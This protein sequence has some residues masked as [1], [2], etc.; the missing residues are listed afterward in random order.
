MQNK[1]LTSLLLLCSSLIC[2]A[3]WLDVHTQI[4]DHLNGVAVNRP[5]AL[6]AGD[7]GLYYSTTGVA[8]GQWQ[9]YTVRGSH[10]DSLVYEHTRFE[11][12]VEGTGATFYACGEDTVAHT[13]ILL[14]V[15]VDAQLYTILYTGSTG[16]A[17][18]QVDDASYNG[19]KYI[20]SAGRAG[21]LVCYAS[22]GST[23]V[24]PTGVTADLVGLRIDYGFATLAAP[25]GVY[26]TNVQG[27]S[28]I[29]PMRYT[30]MTGMDIH[31]ALQPGLITYMGWAVGSKNLQW[32]FNS[33]LVDRAG[34]DHG[35]LNATCIMPFR[36]YC[37]T[38]SDHGI[39]RRASN[40][41]YFMEI[42]PSTLGHSFSSMA[43]SAG[44]DSAYACGD[45]GLLMTTA[46]SGATIPYA[47]IRQ[48]GACVNIPLTVG[49][50]SG[51]GSKRWYKNGVYVGSNNSFT[52]TSATPRQD[53]ITLIMTNTQG[54]AD[55]VSQIAYIV[56]VPTI[57][58]PVTVS[59]PLSC[60]GAPTLIRLDT[61]EANVRYWITDY[62]THRVCSDTAT[63]TGRADTIYG[64]PQSTYSNYVIQASNALAYCEA[65]STNP[66]S[67]ASEYTRARFYADRANAYPGESVHLYQQ[68]NDASYYSWTLSPQPN[69]VSG[70]QSGVATA[71]WTIPGPTQVTLICIS[72]HGCSDTIT[73]PGPTITAEAPADSCWT[74]RHRGGIPYPLSPVSGTLTA[75]LG[76]YVQAMYDSITAATRAG[77]STVPGYYRTLGGYYLARYS[78]NGTMRWQIHTNGT[79]KAVCVDHAQHLYV[80]G[81]GSWLIDNR[82]DSLASGIV[83]PVYYP[84]TTYLACLDSNGTTLWMR[85]LPDVGNI[86]KITADYDGNIIAACGSSTIS[87]LTQVTVWNGQTQLSYT[88]LRDSSNFA[89]VKFDTAGMPLWATSFFIGYLNRGGISGLQ[90]DKYGNIYMAGQTDGGMYFYSDDSL[91]H[92]DFARSGIFVN[93][94]DPSGHMMWN[95]RGYGGIAPYD[96]TYLQSMYTDSTGRTY[97][98]GKCGTDTMRITGTDQV[99]TMLVYPDGYVASIGPAGDCSWIANVKGL[100]SINTAMLLAPCDSGVAVCIAAAPYHAATTSDA[101]IYGSGGTYIDVQQILSSYMIARYTDRGDLLNTMRSTSDSFNC[102]FEML[103]FASA[104]PATY[105][106]HRLQQMLTPSSVL[107][108]DMGVAFQTDRAH[109]YMTS[110]VTGYRGGLLQRS[111]I[112]SVR[113]TTCPHTPYYWHGRTCYAPGWYYD[114]LRV[115]GGRDSIICL[116]LAAIPPVY[117]WM[118]DTICYGD[119]AYF[120]GTY[121][122]QSGIYRDTASIAGGCDSVTV[123]RLTVRA[124]QRD[125]MTA[126]ICQG[127]SFLFAG[128]ELNTTGWYHDTISGADGCPHVSSLNL[129][130]TPHIPVL[131][132]D[133]NGYVVLDAVYIP[134]SYTWYANGVPIPGGG[135][136]YIAG[137]PDTLYYVVATDQWGCTARSNTVVYY[138]LGVGGT[139]DG[140]SISLSPNPASGSCILSVRG[141]GDV[142]Y[143][144][145]DIS[146][147]QVLSPVP[148]TAEQVQIPLHKYTPGVYLV[149][150]ADA[151][152]GHWIQRLTIR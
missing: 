97:I 60:R 38:S 103:D 34:F 66:I 104:G 13:A 83:S 115:A 73:M 12:C 47:S 21:L 135:N 43:I 3:D 25:D 151:K 49:Y 52:Y 42:M 137:L 76:G 55:T 122:R 7:H 58:L 91:P 140:R 86:S 29:V 148:M 75:Y 143:W 27:A 64:Y 35:P 54:Y 129:S 92:T 102:D 6:L 69:G 87:Q 84:F 112:T 117:R 138:A 121:Y 41:V 130:V 51:V 109:T 80:A 53:T 128:H 61:T 33:P 131:S 116:V 114:T 149:H 28:A 9:R 150:V 146:G 15:D 26:F 19:V 4:N 32:D 72:Q 63:A 59:D 101:R 147:R 18:H 118:A 139:E 134:M 119:S 106:L 113:D 141:I 88:R 17:L 10:A 48:I 5:Y 20:Y 70:L 74:L 110:K 77:D 44:G 89:L 105:Y 23:T 14:K 142:S 152:N 95:L 108:H 90:T 16:S 133:N 78:G 68:C 123:F 30:S 24:L 85:T 40:D 31:S 96:F 8:G 144:M 56:A 22:N 65:T 2:R 50:G 67:L 1:I 81:G 62:A 107:Y 145:E 124:W 132:I 93:K 39:Y 37:F 71:T 46:D 11:H 82:G 79:I 98:G 111:A 94:Y 136:G 120:A 100:Y 36:G 45:N 126:H 125:T 57:N 127:D 99:T